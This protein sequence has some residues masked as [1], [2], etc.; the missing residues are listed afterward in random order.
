MAVLVQE[1]VACVFAGP[2]CAT[3]S[4]TPGLASLSERET[5][6]RNGSAR[7]LPPTWRILS[8]L[9]H[10]EYWTLKLLHYY[11]SLLRLFQESNLIEVLDCH[12]GKTNTHSQVHRS[13][14]AYCCPL[15][16]INQ[17]EITQWMKQL[18]WHLLIW[19][20]SFSSSTFTANDTKDAKDL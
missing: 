2:G 11:C 13:F 10:S 1:K 5:G 12:S 14:L 18:R 20:S 4:P 19:L 8:G 3:R 15:I 9:K 7:A 16:N 6:L 17:W